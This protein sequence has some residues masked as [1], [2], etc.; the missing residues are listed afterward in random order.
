MAARKSRTIEIPYTTTDMYLA[1]YL[2]TSGHRLERLT[3]SNGQVTF[4]FPSAARTDAD[5]YP[6]STVS[7]LQYVSIVK[8]LKSAIAAKLAPPPPPMGRGEKAGSFSTS[9][10]GAA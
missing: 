8:A 1:A 7:T 3:S 10:E 6:L 2:V 5:H 9:G 4:E